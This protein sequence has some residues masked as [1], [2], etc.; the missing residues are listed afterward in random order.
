MRYL[1][2]QFLPAMLPLKGLWR[3][4][5]LKGK[6]LSVGLAGAMGLPGFGA[7]LEMVISDQSAA[8]PSAPF[9]NPPQESS[10]VSAMGDVV[11]IPDPVVEIQANVGISTSLADLDVVAYAN[12][13]ASTS[14]PV[15]DVEVHTNVGISTSLAIGQTKIVGRWLL[16]YL[17]CNFDNQFGCRRDRSTTHAIISL[18]H[19]WMS[20][21][22]NGG[23]GAYYICRL[24]LS[25]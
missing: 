23:V 25:F 18:L 12:V 20:S 16:P 10:D 6:V 15:L 9:A 4:W 2:L 3:G 8:F 11:E 1:P 5:R 17:E 21:L 19:S 13:G 7:H 22:D 14:L 24:P